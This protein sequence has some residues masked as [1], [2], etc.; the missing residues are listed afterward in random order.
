MNKLKITVVIV[1]VA[2]IAG[3][4]GYIIGG[5]PA[6]SAPE[7]TA[8]TITSEEASIPYDAPPQVIKRVEPQYPAKMLE[9]GTEAKIYLK[10]FI[11]TEGNVKDAQAFKT[12]VSLHQ[13]TE[14][15]GKDFIS[16]ADSD[17]Q[18]SATNAARQWKF[19]PAKM[20]GKPVGVSV[21][22]P[23]HFKLMSGSVKKK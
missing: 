12:I 9:T 17:F 11:D 6:P 7:R 16:V 20:Q 21:V 3:V 13:N 5:R 8:G 2:C 22:I 4:I 15:A 23:F 18:A 10:V 1:A 14:S 19:E